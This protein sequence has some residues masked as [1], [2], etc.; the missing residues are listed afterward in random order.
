VISLAIGAD[1]YLA[2]TLTSKFVDAVAEDF[3]EIGRILVDWHSKMQSESTQTLN[4]KKSVPSD[5]MPVMNN[6]VMPPVAALV[7]ENSDAGFDFVVPRVFQIIRKDYSMDVPAAP[8][9]NRSVQTMK[10]V[11]S[12]AQLDKSSGVFT[13]SPEDVAALQAGEKN[14]VVGIGGTDLQFSRD[15]FSAM[16]VE[17]VLS[18]TNENPVTLQFDLKEA[19]KGT[20]IDLF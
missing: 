8:L 10:D 5:P 7:N 13:F 2:S 20:S 17:E 15:I 1:D 6:Q 11:M 19:A 14:L 4:E 18:L 12:M 3:F 9:K 16:T